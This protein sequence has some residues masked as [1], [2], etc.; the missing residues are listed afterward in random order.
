MGNCNVRRDFTDVR[1]VVRAYLLLIE[2]GR[3][4]EV[5]NVCSGKAVKLQDILDLLLSLS[6]EKIAVEVDEHRLRKV[7]I[8]LLAGDNRKIR[9]EIAWQPEIPLRQTLADL[10]NHWRQQLGTCP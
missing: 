3:S 8:P 2:K 10:L 9:E 6:K 4:G 5:Y 7:D 1:D